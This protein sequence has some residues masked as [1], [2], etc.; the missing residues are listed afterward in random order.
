MGV[1]RRMML[2]ARVLAVPAV[3][4]GVVTAIADRA[5]AAAGDLDPTFGSGGVAT[6]SY[7]P[8]GF[9]GGKLAIQ[10]NG[11][12]LVAGNVGQL[13]GK[14]LVTARLKPNGNLDG[15][16]RGGMVI[17]NR[18]TFFAVRRE[19]RTPPDGKVVVIGHVSGDL[20]VIR[21]NRD[22]TADQTF[23]DGGRISTSFPGAFNPGDLFVQPDGKIVVAGTVGAVFGVVRYTPPA[24][25]IPPLERVST[26]GL[27]SA[28]G[29]PAWSS[30]PS[31][32]SITAPSTRLSRRTAGSSSS[33]RTAARSE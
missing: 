29:G 30:A 17:T 23:G 3:M 19:F 26:L 8:D 28:R 13:W 5:G 6:L 32:R 12:I 7:D 22:G 21:Y 20:F 18:T 11:R 16:F 9:S 15:T 27:R 14:G 2:L 31:E 25:S 1:R 10:P 4:L 33:D 24:P